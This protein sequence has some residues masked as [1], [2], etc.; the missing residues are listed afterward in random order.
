MH[1][2]ILHQKNLMKTM[3]A[4]FPLKITKRWVNNRSGGGWSI[5]S[6][7]SRFMYVCM[8]WGDQ[9]EV[10]SLIAT[11]HCHSICPWSSKQHGGSFVAWK[12]QTLFLYTHMSPFFSFSL[13][14][15]RNKDETRLQNR[16]SLA[17]LH[18]LTMMWCTWQTIYQQFI[19]YFIR[20]QNLAV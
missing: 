20:F 15:L 16:K 8:E 19:S 17:A 11:C 2:A 18:Q 3:S 5:E 4:V 7:L 6:W 1:T 9:A 10:S 13:D 12:E 14:L